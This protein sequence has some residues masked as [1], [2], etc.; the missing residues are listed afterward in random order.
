[1]Y[2]ITGA[3][4]HVG[5]VA[6]QEL[7]RAGAP[8]RVVV[9]DATRRE[10]W[11]QHGAETAVADFNDQV[12][13]T[14]ALGGSDGAF[15]LLPT[16]PTGG[17]AEHRQLADSIASAVGASGV[18]HVVLLSS[19]GADLADGTGPIRWLHHLENRLRQT[20]VL[21]TAIRSWHFQE[22]VETILGAALHADIYPVFGETADVPTTMIATR[23]IGKAV[24]EA[25]LAPPPASEVIDLEGPEYTEREVAA[26][27]AAALGKPLRVVTIP[28][29]G[30]VDA[31]VGAGLPTPFAHE[32]AALYDAEQRGDLQARGNRRLTCATPI[33]E[34]VRRVVAASA[35]PI[36]AT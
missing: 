1:M 9:R 26:E 11:A 17:D 25:L 8:V 27:L 14:R 21:L 10:T 32:L 13:L 15:I 23:D 18:P 12:A 35:G 2:T 19:I 33:D 4:G 36:P 31:L 7:L 24:A 5:A 28:R 29:P 30:W 3:T 6:A 20:D 22:K 16:I 34:T